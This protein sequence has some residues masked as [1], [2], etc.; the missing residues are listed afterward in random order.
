[1][2]GW[3]RV[4]KHAL[5]GGEG[6]SG[7][8]YRCRDIARRLAAADGHEPRLDCLGQE[9][10]PE[11]TGG[12]VILITAEDDA[13]E[14][15]IRWNEIDPTGEM[16]QR[17]AGRLIAIPMDNIGGEIGRESCRERAGQYV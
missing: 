7:K 10:R 3:D 15:A 4:G 6:A 8:I 11:A 13:D 1:M 12:T 14:L 16:R 9:I 17:A 5:L 2:E